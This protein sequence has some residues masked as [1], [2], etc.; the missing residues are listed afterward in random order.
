VQATA[1]KNLSPSEKQYYGKD[2]LQEPLDASGMASPQV[3]YDMASPQV[4]SGSQK[5]YL[6]M[7]FLQHDTSTVTAF[8]G[9]EYAQ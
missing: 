4:S 3:T 7:D 2:I 9:S 6:G 8:D 5:Q 1:D